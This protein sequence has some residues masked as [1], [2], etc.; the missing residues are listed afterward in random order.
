MEYITNE[1]VGIS[2]VAG[3]TEPLR[4]NKTPILMSQLDIPTPFITPYH[5]HKE[6]RR[7]TLPLFSNERTLQRDLPILMSRKVL[8]YTNITPYLHCRL[9][10]WC[11]WYFWMTYSCLNV[12]SSGPSVYVFAPSINAEFS[13]TSPI[14]PSQLTIVHS[15]SKGAF[16]VLVWLLRIFSLVA[17][18]KGCCFLNRGIWK[19]ILRE[20]YYHM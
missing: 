3:E 20:H 12:N 2:V 14:V 9:D 19:M 5:V 4:T 6:H 8:L 11:S 7:S 10:F 13:P 16:W 17:R 1:W 18:L 15:S